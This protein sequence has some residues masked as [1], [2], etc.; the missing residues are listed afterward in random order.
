MRT[1]TF[2]AGCLA[3]IVFTASW[4]RPAATGENLPVPAE[5]VGCLALN[6]YWEAR[7]EP[8]DSRLAVAQVVLNRVADAR[9]PDTICDVVQENRLGRRLHACQFSW[10]CDGASDKPRELSQWLEAVRLAKQVVR[11]VRDRSRGS[12]WYHATY[13]KPDWATRL[14]KAVKL[15]RHVFYRDPKMVEVAMGE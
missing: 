8:L 6:I 1:P 10:Y 3:V 12:L 5:E 4:S 7:S 13:V 2:I 11:G 14:D 15:G 9:F